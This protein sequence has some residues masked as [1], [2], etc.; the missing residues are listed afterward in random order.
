[1]AINEY[2]CRYCGKKTTKFDTS[3]KPSPGVCPRKGKN[4][5]H[6]WVKNRKI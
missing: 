2:M 6:S 1:M 4:Q 3:G 5:P